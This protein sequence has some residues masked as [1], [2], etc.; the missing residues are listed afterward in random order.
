[1]DISS[2]S[3]TQPET[4]SWAAL[5]QGAQ[6]LVYS[7]IFGSSVALHAVNVFVATT[8]MPS[9]VADIGGLEV[10]AW[11]STVFVAASIVSAALVS[12]LLAYGGANKAYLYASVIFIA[13][14]LL[15]ATAPNIWA[16]IF[17]RTLQ[18]LGGG[19]FYALSYA[20]IR[21][22]YPEKLWP[23]AIGL[24][25]V[26]WGIATLIGPAIGGTFVE[27]A[28][29]RAAFWSLVPCTALIA[30]AAYL[31]M[32]RQLGEH[33]AESAKIPAVQ[34][35]LVLSIVIVVSLG[36]ID[37]NALRVAG[38]LLLSALLIWILLSHENNSENRLFPRRTLEGNSALGQHYLCIGLLLIGMQAEVFA[39][40][41]LQVLH[42]QSPLV[43]GYM[44]ALMALG[45]TAGS[46]TTAS[47]SGERAAQ[48]L[49][50]GPLLGLAGLLLQACVFPLTPA[51]SI[52][53][54]CLIA[55][56]MLLVG[57]GIGITW[58]HVVTRIYALAP[59]DEQD[60]SAG[61]VTTVQL[62]AT[63]LGAAAGGMIVNL[64]GMH[65]PGG[66]AGAAAAARW[67]C[68]LFALAPLFAVL[69]ARRA[70]RN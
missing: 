30:V 63:A 69:A 31:S 51:G 17:G 59:R 16:L 36:S 14:T 9:V 61:A 70:L 1:M 60:L 28:T 53:L 35:A 4:A 2:T 47:W 57:F 25:T 40:Y 67:L 18:G 21:M 66:V 19:F 26:M 55:A 54:L 37:P 29:W 8:I 46:M 68:L 22:V 58:P 32:P 48:T 3:T 7:L 52:L 50:A 13:G 44:G 24:I 10:Y 27:F 62:F 49:V 45:W 41:L 56:G 39:P 42:A 33:Q 43:A 12:Q 34:I 23:V 11:S 64:A 65:A 5:F 38:S 20:V 6:R 15:C